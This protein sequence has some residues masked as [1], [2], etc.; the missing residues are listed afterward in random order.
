MELE[1]GATGIA[2][3]RLGK[4]PPKPSCG[5][6]KEEIGGDIR[7]IRYQPTG[8]KQKWRTGYYAPAIAQFE[9]REWLEQHVGPMA[10]VEIHG[11]IS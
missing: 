1:H 10:H 2:G 5:Y 7:V 4:T 3:P 11:S 6:Y 8:A 9:P